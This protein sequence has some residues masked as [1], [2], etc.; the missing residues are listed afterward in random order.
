MDK[1]LC[2]RRG[3]NVKNKLF[4]VL[5]VM[6][7]IV[8]GFVGVSTK[9]LKNYDVLMVESE[10]HLG[11]G[12]LQRR[13]VHGMYIPKNCVWTMEEV[14]KISLDAINTVELNEIDFNVF[15]NYVDRRNTCLRSASIV[16]ITVNTLKF[17]IDQ[18]K[19]NIQSCLRVVSEFTTQNCKII[20]VGTK[21]DMASPYVSNELK[22]FS[23]EL[24]LNYIETSAKTG[25]GIDLLMDCIKQHVSKLHENCELAV[26]PKWS[27][28][29]MLFGIVGYV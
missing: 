18:L 11:Q 5:T 14:F 22:M 7:I 4:R 24:N 21:M 16:L 13:I 12:T 8:L 6:L 10:E 26:N 27:W 17:N 19:E 9:A 25:E 3:V 15:R 23:K 1:M 29:K 28:R 20:L 2:L